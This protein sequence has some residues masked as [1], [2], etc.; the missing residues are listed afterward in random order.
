M[1]IAVEKRTFPSMCASRLIWWFY[2]ENAIYFLSVCSVENIL[3]NENNEFLFASDAVDVLAYML[4]VFGYYEQLPICSSVRMACGGRQP[5]RLVNI[6]SFG[7]VAS[8]VNTLPKWPPY[9]TGTETY[10]RRY[11]PPLNTTSQSGPRAKLI[12]YP[13]HKLTKATK[14]L[15][16]LL[17]R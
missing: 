3:R 13:C 15:P 17:C 9:A 7:L 2:V 4:R 5:P 6:H 14:K 1:F 10:I 8:L 11:G 12:A 16:H